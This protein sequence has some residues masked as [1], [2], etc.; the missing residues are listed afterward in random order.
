[1]TRIFETIRLP[2]DPTKELKRVTDDG[3][4]LT[5]DYTDRFT[6]FVD[7]KYRN[8]W[9]KKLS[10][11]RERVI[12]P[13]SVGPNGP[14]LASSHLDAIAI[15][16]D[17][18]LE[19]AITE[20]NVINGNSWMNRL[21]INQID[22]INENKRSI[23]KHSKLGF[24]SEGGGKTRMFAICDYWSQ[25]SLK[26]IHDHQMKILKSLGTDGT[27]DQNKAFERVLR[28]SKGK[29]TYSYDLE[30]AS[31]RIPLSQQVIRMK[32]I[33]GNTIAEL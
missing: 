9:S 24:S 21:R 16:N 12:Y 18:I 27:Y 20:I 28:E 8:H 3:V 30:G 15:D 26:S 2:I 6:Q 7:L 1:M 22:Q 4:F 14:A 29:K 32:S 31:H 23:V 19:K 13:A 33:Y 25:L 10:L 5:K 17:V 11:K